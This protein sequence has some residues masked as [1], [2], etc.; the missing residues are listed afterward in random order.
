MHSG[1]PPIR[2][3]Q[4]KKSLSPVRSPKRDPAGSDGWHRCPG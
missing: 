3:L 4:I 1:I 2:L